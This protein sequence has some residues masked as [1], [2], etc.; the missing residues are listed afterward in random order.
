MQVVGLSN[1]PC[2]PDMLI[3][4]LPVR[5]QLSCLKYQHATAS[6][7]CCGSLFGTRQLYVGSEFRWSNLTCGKVSLWQTRSGCAGPVVASCLCQAAY[8]VSPQPAPA[9]KETQPVFLPRF[10]YTTCVTLLYD[11]VR[12]K[13]T[14]NA[15]FRFRMCP[16]STSSCWYLS[17]A[18][19]V[20]G[21][22]VVGQHQGCQGTWT[23]V[24]RR[25][26]QQFSRVAFGYIFAKMLTNVCS[27]Y[28]YVQCRIID[29]RCIV[30]VLWYIF[31]FA[32]IFWHCISS[33]S[34][35]NCLP[36]CRFACGSYGSFG[37]VWQPE[38]RHLWN[39]SCV[40]TCLDILEIHRKSRN[41]KKKL[42]ISCSSW[43]WSVSPPFLKKFQYDC[44]VRQTKHLSISW[45][46]WWIGHQHEALWEFA[47][48][49]YKNRELGMYPKQ[50]V[51]FKLT[52]PNS[53]YL[54]PKK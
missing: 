37:A 48:A 54:P 52:V 36:C 22:L 38:D 14:R 24:R 5:V 1:Q 12:I 11:T 28:M 15:L 18:C 32:Y 40:T 41:L 35:I 23:V 43:R 51:M 30:L 42:F 46:D 7:N 20:T 8:D 10:M 27:M 13:G 50:G 49:K 29:Y 33:I 9:C 47:V 44:V 25:C 16:Y 3:E 6:D 4:R 21:H 17:D 19:L 45:V 31:I 26:F 39:A 2:L 53:T 34:M